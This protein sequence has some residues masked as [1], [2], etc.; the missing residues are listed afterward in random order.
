VEPQNKQ[1]SVG[2]CV[3]CTPY[4]FDNRRRGESS[5]NQEKRPIRTVHSL[6]SNDVRQY[7]G[8]SIGQASYSTSPA[9]FEI[10][11]TSQ[12]RTFAISA[13]RAPYILREAG[14][15]LINGVVVLPRLLPRTAVSLSPVRTRT[16]L[17]VCVWNPSGLRCR[18]VNAQGSH[19]QFRERINAI[20][21][22]ITAS[23][24]LLVEF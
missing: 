15:L 1:F 10:Q 13:I 20:R 18:Y 11:Q 6:H 23:G 21:S 17:F 12:L 5:Q 7:T 9:C 8:Q 14:R 3:L 19:F 2:S 16:V 22:Q 4:K 24:G